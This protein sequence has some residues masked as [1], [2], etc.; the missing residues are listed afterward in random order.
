MRRQSP[1]H[2]AGPTGAAGAAWLCGLTPPCVGV[3]KRQCLVGWQDVQLRLVSKYIEVRLW[4]SNCRM[5]WYPRGAQ[6]CGSAQGPWAG[7]LLLAV[8]NTWAP[9]CSCL[10]HRLD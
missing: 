8:Y 1:G 6:Q 4:A 9:L 2:G 7:A 3:L 5:P 10:A